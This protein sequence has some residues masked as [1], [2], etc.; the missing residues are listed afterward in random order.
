MNRAV[1]VYVMLVG[2]AFCEGIWLLQAA[3][4]PCD[5]STPGTAKM[6]AGD[7]SCTTFGAATCPATA[8]NKPA[9]YPID[10]SGTKQAQQPYSVLCGLSNLKPVCT[11]SINCSKSAAGCAEGNPVDPP[12]HSYG[13]AMFGP[14]DCA[15]PHG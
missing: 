14:V 8:T 9:S 13:P 11:T 1:T 4:D 5:G 3:A 7:N 2:L 15:V 10:C 12:A 6:C